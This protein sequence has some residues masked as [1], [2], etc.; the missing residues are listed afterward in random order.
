MVYDL[1]LPVKLQKKTIYSFELFTT[2]HNLSIYVNLCY[3]FYAQQKDILFG[4]I[5]DSEL[6][7]V[8]SPSLT[9]DH[10]KMTLRASFI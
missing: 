8:E 10:V 3:M 9:I 4:T 7:S 6:V 5:A 2:I 1:R